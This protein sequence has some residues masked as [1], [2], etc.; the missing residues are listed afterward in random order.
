MEEKKTDS[1]ISKDSEAENISSFAKYRGKLKD[2]YSTDRTV[3]NRL[4]EDTSLASIKKL[5]TTSAQELF[6]EAI[7]KP[8]KAPEISMAA[9]YMSDA[10]ASIINYY[11]TFF[12]IRYTIIPRL[13][14]EEIW[15]SDLDETGQL[16][17][18]Y[19][20]IYYKMTEGV[21]GLNLETTLPAIAEEALIKGKCGVIT[22]K[23]KITDT[24]VTYFL[25]YQYYKTVGKT[26]FGTN[27]IAFDFKYFDNL[28]SKSVNSSS[29]TV[30]DT[31]FESILKSM[32]K[33]LQEGYAK[34]EKNNNL[35]WQVLEPKFATEFNFNELSI[36]PKLGAFPAS[37]DYNSYKDIKLD[38]AAQQLDTILVHQ[39]PTNS[40]G[41]LIMEVDEALSVASEMRKALS[42]IS[43]LKVVTAF[44]KTDLYNLQAKTSEQFDVLNTA[45]NNIYSSAG[46]DYHV[47]VS[48]RDLEV[49]LR[50]DKAFMWD[51]YQ[52]VMLFYNVT[53]NEL[54][55]FNP[56]Q[57]KINL[58]PI[59]VQ[60][61]QEDVKRFIE[62][63]GAGIG[64]LQA[65]A[66]TGMKQVDLEDGFNVEKFLNFD[67]ILKPLQSMYT[68]SYKANLDDKE[69]EEE[70]QNKDESS[71][72]QDI[73][74][75]E[76]NN[77]SAG[78]EE[79]K[80]SNL[81]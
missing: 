38:A 11:K 26:Q 48:D 35:R 10:Y 37:V 71:S 69:A 51:F 24:V 5:K 3:S 75:E 63:A 46:V 74:P 60:M 14:Q 56:Y 64:R 81:E 57:C 20:K 43:N 22:E 29:K 15:S 41:D 49:S 33:L 19:G 54:I 66:A 12:Y 34:Y 8:E 77:K 6:S 50:R 47:F 28:K 65:V 39:I 40:E 32:P 58:L 17:E 2:L 21:E 67:K 53:F 44:G 80:V 31:N 62:Y 16:E 9:Y 70:E 13:L 79:D 78:E 7:S 55:N 73:E 27:I 68:S 30:E 42:S 45:Y 1:N 76:S 18:E 36:P 72:I 25:P 61:E 4:G 52:R 59:S 23:H